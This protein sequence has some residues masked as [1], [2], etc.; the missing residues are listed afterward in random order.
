[1]EQKQPQWLLLV[2]AVVNLHHNFSLYS[3]INQAQ[4][5]A[6]ISNA[7][8]RGG[9]VGISGG[10]WEF[11]REVSH[12]MKCE[13]TGIDL[14]YSFGKCWLSPKSWVLWISRNYSFRSAP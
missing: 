14:L 10:I 5:R 1:L 13:I 2:F 12:E 6:N 11:H 9:D 3:L 8:G 4:K 7:N